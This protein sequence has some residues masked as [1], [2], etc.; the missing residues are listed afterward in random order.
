MLQIPDENNMSERVNTK[1]VCGAFFLFF[2]NRES[3][4]EQAVGREA[5]N[6]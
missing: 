4:Q 6:L 3:S 1:F 2:V 5:K